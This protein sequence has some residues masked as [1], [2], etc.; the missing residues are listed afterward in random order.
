MQMGLGGNFWENVYFGF[1]VKVGIF[2]FF[3]EKPENN[4]PFFPHVQRISSQSKVNTAFLSFGGSNLL[5][6]IILSVF[7]YMDQKK[8]YFQHCSA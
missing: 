2:F 4:V 7:G 1:L 8:I 6:K 3:F 5:T